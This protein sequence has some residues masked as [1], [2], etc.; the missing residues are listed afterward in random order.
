MITVLIRHASV[1]ELESP[2]TPYIKQTIKVLTRFIF[3]FILTDL[4]L[5]SLL[6]DIGKQHSPRCDATERGV[7]SGAILYA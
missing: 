3:T 4:S 1:E 2:D 6:L 5:A 7:P